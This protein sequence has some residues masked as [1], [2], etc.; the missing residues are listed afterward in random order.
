MGGAILS[1]PP[2]LRL[3]AGGGGGFTGQFQETWSSNSIRS[4]LWNATTNTSGTGSASAATGALVLSTTSAGAGT[5]NVTNPGSSNNRYDLTTAGAIANGF[6]VDVQSTTVPANAFVGVEDS[7]GAGFGF[8]I[9][10][11]TSFAFGRFSAGAGALGTR[12][13][14]VSTGTYTPGTDRYFRFR[15]AA[16][17]VELATS[18]DGMTWNVKQTLANT[19][20]VTLTAVGF[21]FDVDSGSSNNSMTIGTVTAN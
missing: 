16:G 15:D 11:S 2:A 5:V 20:G 18:P 10:T 13:V 1:R 14:S 3:N 8:A 4:T 17:S 19:G 9:Q 7:T 12:F 21:A 6:T